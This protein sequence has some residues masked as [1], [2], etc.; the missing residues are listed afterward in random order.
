MRGLLLGLGAIVLP[1]LAGPLG[2]AEAGHYVLLV[3]LL[4]AI[5]GEIVG[6][7]LFFVSVVP[8]HLAA[9]YIASASEAA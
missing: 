6:R 3:A 5:A 7:Y 4:L 1:L 8:K 2:P 9:P